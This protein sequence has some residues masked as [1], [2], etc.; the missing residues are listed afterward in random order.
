MT[1]V[2]ILYSLQSSPCPSPL[3]CAG[4]DDDDVSDYEMASDDCKAQAAEARAQKERARAGL[5][6]L[7]LD[8]LA[9]SIAP[10]MLTL[11]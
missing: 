7:Q 4:S 8:Q 3:T 2:C 11:S 1:H 5:P 10:K 6:E 9:S